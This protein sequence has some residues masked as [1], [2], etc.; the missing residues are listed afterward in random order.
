MKGYKTM[1]NNNKE[2]VEKL[3]NELKEL[4]KEKADYDLILKKSQELDKYIFEE[5]I[6]INDIG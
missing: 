2:V 6:D 4:I 3:R 5:L 1:N